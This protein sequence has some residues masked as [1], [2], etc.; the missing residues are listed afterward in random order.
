MSPGTM[1]LAR[2]RTLLGAEHNCLHKD[3]ARV[4]PSIDKLI[5]HANKEWRH[6]C[7][8]PISTFERNSNIHTVQIPN[9][10]VVGTDRYA[11]SW[12][13]ASIRLYLAFLSI[14][15]IW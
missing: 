5:R 14:I 1:N 10:R 7:T 3:G 9:K 4:A 6:S 11:I 8:V 15:S 12:Y 2:F 13:F